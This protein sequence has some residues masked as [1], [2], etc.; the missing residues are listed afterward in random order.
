ML[1]RATSAGDQ[2]PSPRVAAAVSASWRGYACAG[3]VRGF[4]AAFFTTTTFPPVADAEE[5]QGPDTPGP[6]A[7]AAAP[8]LA[9]AGVVAAG[10]VVPTSEP[11]L[12]CPDWPGPPGDCSW[13]VM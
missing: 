13:P 11:G 4:T 10:A 1:Q 8:P 9:A 6:V 2:P 5:D 7:T 12:V 3:S